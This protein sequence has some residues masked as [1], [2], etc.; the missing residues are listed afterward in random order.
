MITIQGTGVSAGIAKGP[1]VF[2]RRTKADHTKQEVR[3]V[4]L[5]KERL[6]AAQETAASQ[7]EMLAE[8]CRA[9]AADA[10]V[11]F[12]T[13]AMFVYDEDLVF[14]IT[15]ILEKERCNAEYAVRQAGEQFAE[16]LPVSRAT[17][18]TRQAAFREGGNLPKAEVATWLKTKPMKPFEKIA[19]NKGY[20]VNAI[21]NFYNAL[22]QEAIEIAA[23]GYVPVE[24]ECEQEAEDD[25]VPENNGGGDFYF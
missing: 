12:E 16:M 25:F 24:L 11:L 15:E 9:D 13:H 5:E 18:V 14:C 2:L 10:A 3:D 21:Q 23:V 17:R 8:K 7:L 6:K 22:Y 20:N 1:L 4:R 19:T